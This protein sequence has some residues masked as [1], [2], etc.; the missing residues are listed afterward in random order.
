MNTDNIVQ[1]NV[2]E[3]ELEEFPEPEK[4]YIVYFTYATE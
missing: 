1:M 2:T 3:T 4:A